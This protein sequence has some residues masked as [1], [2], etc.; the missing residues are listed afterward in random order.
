MNLSYWRTF[1][2]IFSLFVFHV[3]R[4]PGT[5]DQNPQG[6]EDTGQQVAK[7]GQAEDQG[8]GDASELEQAPAEIEIKFSVKCF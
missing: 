7:A 2:I 6:D 3:C 4:D 8:N 1:L 5:S